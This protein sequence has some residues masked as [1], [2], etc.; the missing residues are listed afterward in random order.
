MV[1]FL[2]VLTLPRRP[3]LK[4]VHR[5]A[6]NALAVGGRCAAIINETILRNLYSLRRL[7]LNANGENGVGL[8]QGLLNRCDQFPRFAST[9]SVW[10]R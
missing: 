5:V 3:L 10:V 7:P 8:V 6:R 4:L 9:A 2:E 1:W